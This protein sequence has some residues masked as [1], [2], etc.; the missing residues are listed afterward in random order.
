MSDNQSPGKPEGRTDPAGQVLTGGHGEERAAL[1]LKSLPGDLADAVL[2]RMVPENATRLRQRMQAVP[3]AGTPEALQALHSFFERVRGPAAP[4]VPAGDTIKDEFVA[5][6]Q[7]KALLAAIDTAP[8]SPS[9]ELAAN[10]AEEELED[11]PG[12]DPVQELRELGAAR[13]A[14]VLRG[15]RTP[16]IVVA[17]SCLPM[18]DASEI[19]KRLVPE[20]RR[21][22]TLRLARNAPSDPQLLRAVARAVVRKGKTLSDDP[23]A[24][25][26]DGAA[27]KLAELLRGLE[28]DDRKEVLDGL[29]ATDPAMAEKVKSMLYVFEDLMRI[30]DRSVQVLLAEVEMKTL[31]QAMTGADDT[32]MTKV[33][34]NL[35]QRARDTLTEEMGLLGKP[36][37]TQIRDARAQVVAVIQRLDSEGKLVM[38]EVE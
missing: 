35:S 16:A 12:S 27:R 26:G 30:E 11:V 4:A 29:A 21:E 25:E 15:E 31:A 17:L 7:A 1:L 34:N 9:R 6:P 38:I 2:G 22:A 8:V 3:A 5:S 18:A 28:R 33:M 32:M 23:A 10:I 13:T 20:R 19:L 14:A 36:R 24:L 37:A